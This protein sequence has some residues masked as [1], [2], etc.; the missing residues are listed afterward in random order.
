MTSRF[1]SNLCVL[2]VAACMAAARFAFNA[3]AVG[4][5]TFGCA[6]LIVITV[7][8]A[9]LARGRVRFSGA[10]TSARRSTQ[11]QRVFAL[12]E[13]LRGVAAF[14]VA[15]I[16]LHL[17]MTVGATPAAGISTAMWVCVGLAAGGALFSGYL[18][19]LGRGR[20]QRPGLAQWNSGD[21][22]A[23]DSPPLA[24]GIRD[25]TLLPPPA[26][27]RAQP[28]DGTRTRASGSPAA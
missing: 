20:L 21:A 13:L 12:I 16:L 15:P 28:T 2:V 10:L 24:A 23:W 3:A 9:F 18:F 19:A 8:V 27:A 22:P 4:W 25:E 11:L 5:L 17:S 26:S 6:C 7:A 1:V 14:M